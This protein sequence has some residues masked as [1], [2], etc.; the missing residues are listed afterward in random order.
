MMA[1]TDLPDC[2][3]CRAAST[4]EAEWAEMGAKFCVCSCCAKRCRVDERNR[5]HRDDVSQIDV[6]GH[7]VYPDP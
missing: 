3:H 5:A 4:L 1:E 2:P 6:S 7:M